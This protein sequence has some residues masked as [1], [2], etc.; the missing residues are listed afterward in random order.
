MSDAIATDPSRCTAEV[1]VRLQ[2]VKEQFYKESIVTFLLDVVLQAHKFHELHS[3]GNEPPLLLMIGYSE[4]MQVWGIPIS[5]EAQELFSV[6]HGPVR[7]ARILPSPQ[8]GAQK[9]DNFAEKRPLLVFCKSIGSSGT[10]P[11]YCCVDLNSLRTE[12][13][14]KSI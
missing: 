1:V 8:L 13:M 5:G 7:A 9:C 11:P 2:A 6:L 12:E 14:V 3:T 10:T 4:G